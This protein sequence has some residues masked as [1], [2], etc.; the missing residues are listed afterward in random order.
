[1]KRTRP[2]SSRSAASCRRQSAAIAVL[3]PPQEEPVDDDTDASP[4]RLRTPLRS[5]LKGSGRK[6]SVP[7]S[8]S[9]AENNENV[10]PLASD[11][12]SPC[13]L[14]S[15]TISCASSSNNALASQPRHWRAQASRDISKSPDD[16]VES[17]ECSR[18][19]C[20]KPVS[21]RNDKR[22]T[23]P[24]A[25]TQIDGSPERPHQNGII[26]PVSSLHS[27]PGVRVLKA[28]STLRSQPRIRLAEA[29]NEPSW[30][31]SRDKRTPV[32]DHQ[33]SVSTDDEPVKKLRS[34][35]K[36]GEASPEQMDGAA[37][38]AL[39]AASYRGSFM[40]LRGEFER[41]GAKDSP[42]LDISVCNVQ[43]QPRA[44]LTKK[45]E[46]PKKPAWS[47]PRRSTPKLTRNGPVEVKPVASKVRGLAAMFD[48]AAKTSPFLPTPGGVVQQKRRETARVISPYTSNPSPR[49]SLLSTTSVSTPVSL[50]NPTRISIDLSNTVDRKSM[51]PRLQNGSATE[52]PGILGGNAAP[53]STRLGESR[54]SLTS[55]NAASRIPTPSRLP[56]RTKPPANDATSLPQL[57]GTNKT[58]VKSPL[59][60]TAQQEIRP[61]GYYSSP[62]LSAR[63]SGAYRG[64]PRLSYHSNTSNFSEGTCQD[65][66]VS[67]SNPSP[68]RGRS[69]SSLR[70]QIRSLRIELSAKNEDCAQLRLELEGARKAQQ[71]NEI[72]LRE[73]LD[74]ARADSIEWR[75]RAETAERKIDGLERLAA[76][77][78]NSRDSGHRSVGYFHGQA[79]DA[80]D[81]YSFASGSDHLDGAQDPLQPLTARMNQSA[82]RTPRCSGYEASSGNI[83]AGDGFS[84]CSSSTVVRNVAREP[85]EDDRG[86]WGTGDELVRLATSGS[87]NECC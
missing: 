67:P 42:N 52:K 63:T 13:R 77:V 57:D 59:R 5:S 14:P 66:E 31:P 64:L 32:R 68:G 28:S 71:V 8:R 39:T 22:Q 47:T 35:S 75:R 78:E 55:S 44:T 58:P 34:R 6:L 48:T 81:E 33:G 82:K 12:D 70:E 38:F 80:A 20:C 11:V 49:D 72:L 9:A 41:R 74:R 19:H 85:H 50:M 86:I 7:A 21:T 87:I 69:A 23:T 65:G 16:E 27:G 29:S 15:R 62:I 30:I 73:D 36:R 61:A 24:K 54:S 18:V 26:D 37:D 56:I 43:S 2:V 84:E 79:G 40:D 1:M 3:S 4:G 76:K 46:K 60:L 45:C 51:I 17:D 83:A 10:S 53:L 25:M